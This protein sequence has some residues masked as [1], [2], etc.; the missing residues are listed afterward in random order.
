MLGLAEFGPIVNVDKAKP[1]YGNSRRLITDGDVK[2]DEKRAH[3]S[4]TPGGASV[5]NADGSFAHEDVWKYLYTH[6]VEEVGQPVPADADC[7]MD[8]LKA[9]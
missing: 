6:P 4:V 7:E 3:S 2:G 9:K 1:P 8:L 5:K